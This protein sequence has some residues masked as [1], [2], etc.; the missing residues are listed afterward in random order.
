MACPRALHLGE[1]PLIS[2]KVPWLVE[3]DSMVESRHRFHLVVVPRSVSVVDAFL[4]GQPV[5]ILLYG[6]GV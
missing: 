5:K 2:A 1:E 6:R 3:E 4:F